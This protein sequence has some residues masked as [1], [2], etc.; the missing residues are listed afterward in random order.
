MQLR[1]FIKQFRFFVLLTLCLALASFVSRAD[2]KQ[3]IIIV[4]MSN[5]LTSFTEPDCIYAI[6]GIVNLKGKTVQIPSN[7]MLDFRKGSITNGILTGNNTQMKSLH[8]KCIGFS[9]KGTWVVPK[10]D[11]VYFDAG[12]LTDDQIITAVNTMQSDSIANRIVLRKTQYNCSIKKNDGCLLRLSSNTKLKLKTSIIIEGNKH[13]SYNIIRI[14]GKE[15]VEITGG[16]LIGDVGNHEYVEGTSSQWGHGVYI[17]NSKHV[18]VE[19]LTVMRCIGDGFTITG[20]S[21]SHYGDMSQASRDVEI[22]NVTARFNRR[23]GISIIYAENVSVTNSVFSDTGTI[24]YHSPSSG[25][26]IEPNLDP[27][28]QTARNITVKNCKFE[29]NV[30]ASI[31]SNHYKSHEDNKSVASVMFYR[32]YCDGRVELHTGGISFNNTR[33][34]S[35]DLYAEKDPLEDMLFTGCRIT[36]NGINL[37]CTKKKNEETWINNIVFDNCRIATS[38]AVLDDND[39]NPVIRSGYTDNINRIELK[40]CKVVGTDKNE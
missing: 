13:N 36:N 39:G 26:D 23:Q 27:Y 40:H 29:R 31:L 11:D 18:K 17:C 3:R 1:M 38:Q 6:V 30:G 35:L 28:F 20:G 7:C 4:N 21:A 12:V 10:I 25:I 37:R 22:N 24:E 19:K 2:N 34:S 16:V 33:M 32:C 9:P 8:K 14:K 15:N 5:V